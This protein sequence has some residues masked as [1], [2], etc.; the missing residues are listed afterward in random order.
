MFEFDAG[1]LIIVGIVA[2]IV[3]GPKE[4]PRVMRRAG[5]AMAK[6][7][8]MAAEFRGQ[9]MD[10]MRESE[11]DDIEARV[12]KLADHMKP[13][14][15]ADPLA[16]IKAELTQALDAAE[17][18][19]ALRVEGATALRDTQK[20]DFA[21]NPPA[22]PNSPQMPGASVADAGNALV[23]HVASADAG[24]AADTEMRGVADALHRRD[25]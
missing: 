13:D 2:L 19:A 22:H 6:M 1:K 12:E 18:P 20:G 16:Q 24:S 7:R 8:R 23:A 11:M 15:G 17:K 9:F 5:E 21:P 14:V 25:R 3:I 4:L 10:A